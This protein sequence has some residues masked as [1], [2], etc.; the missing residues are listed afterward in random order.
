MKFS[1][2]INS[3]LFEYLLRLGDDMLIIGH[4][5]SEWCGHAPILEEDI[6]LSNISLDCIGHA[7]VLLHTAAELENKNRTEDDLAYFRDGMEFRNLLLT[8]LPKGDFAFT[9]ARQ[10]LFDVYALHLYNKLQFSQFEILKGVSQKIYKELK[11]HLRHSQEWVLRLGDGTNESHER[12][13]IAFDELWMYTGELFYFDDIEELLWREGIVPEYSTELKDRWEQ[14]VFKIIKDATLNIPDSSQYMIK[15]GR[16]GIHSEHLGHL[17]SEM[18][19][20]ARSYP[21]VKW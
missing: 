9:I 8:E 12:M 13:Q 18:Q 14:L 17:L 3:A 4:R 11:Y 6:A 19:I 5:L 10:F 15:G 20:V 21:G 1:E 16:N 7:S 2:R